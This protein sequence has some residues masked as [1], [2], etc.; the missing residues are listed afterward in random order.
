[1]RAA[2]ARAGADTSLTGAVRVFGKRV[3]IISIC[4]GYARGLTATLLAQLA[5]RDAELRAHALQLASRGNE[6]KAPSS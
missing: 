6:L 1:M 5:E 4:F 3:P 2:A